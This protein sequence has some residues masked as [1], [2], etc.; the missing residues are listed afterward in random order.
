[1]K[2]MVIETNIVRQ[3][4]SEIM[5]MIYDNPKYI[6]DN[7][8]DSTNE[9]LDIENIK[10]DSRNCY[11]EVTCLNSIK[12]WCEKTIVISFRDIWE[13]GIELGYKVYLKSGS[14]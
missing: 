6:Y 13:M 1:M 8:M 10:F 9:L 2:M 14:N 12:E 5:V 3:T 4:L 7:F 11:I